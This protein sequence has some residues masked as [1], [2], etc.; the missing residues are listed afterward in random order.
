M[1]GDGDHMVRRRPPENEEP[2]SFW[3]AFW[4]GITMAGLFSKPASTYPPYARLA[5]IC[6]V[7]LV[8]AFIGACAFLV[9]DGH[10]FA[11]GGLLGLASL[12]SLTGR[13]ARR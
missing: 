1:R 2:P 6:A 12:A 9:V 11:A 13:A 4:D 7:A 8:L 10:P 3:T 5:V